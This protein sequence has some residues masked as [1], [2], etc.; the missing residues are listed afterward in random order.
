MNLETEKS[1]DLPFPSWRPRKADAVIQSESKGLR[2]EGADDVHPSP[3]AGEDEVRGPSS[4]SEAGKNGVN[5]FFFRLLF[6]SS[7]QQTE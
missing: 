4:S 3:R 1:R 5:F 7:P 2:S 6:Y